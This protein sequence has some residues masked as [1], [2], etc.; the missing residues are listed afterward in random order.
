MSNGKGLKERVMEL[1]D[2]EDM[3]YSSLVKFVKNHDQGMNQLYVPVAIGAVSLPA[4]GYYLARKKS[5]ESK[6]GYAALGIGATLLI[7]W[8][9]YGM[10]RADIYNFSSQGF[11][12]S[13]YNEFHPAKGPDSSSSIMDYVTFMFTN[14]DLAESLMFPPE[15]RITKAYV[16]S[17]NDGDSFSCSYELLDGFII[18]KEIQYNQLKLTNIVF[19]ANSIKSTKIKEVVEDF[20]K[21]RITSVQSQL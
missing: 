15:N 14:I 18:P 13:H 12:V 19:R 21:D 9:N 3:W 4:L 5:T 2:K 16:S 1:V 17:N 10:Q 8:I 7:G 20:C 11:Q 6:L